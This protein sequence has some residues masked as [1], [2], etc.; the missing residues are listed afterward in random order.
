MRANLH[1]HSRF[2]DGTNWPSEVAAR[3]AAAGIEHAALTDHDTLRGGIE[4]AEA[5]AR[6]GLV[7]TLGV[8]IDCREPSL[9]Y[10]SELLAY[11]PEGAY[12]R[13]EAFLEEIQAERRRVVRSALEAA[14]RHFFNPGL[15]SFE[16]LLDRKRADRRD[17]PAER[18][19]FNKVDVYLLL[20][21][22]GLIPPDVA[23]RTFKRTYFDSRVLLDRAREKPLCAEVCRTVLSDGGVLVIPH[24]G[25]EFGDDL[26][27]LSSGI[28]RL[29]KLLKYFR[30]IGVG[31]VEL[32]YY[33]NG[34]SAEINKVVRREAKS[35]GFFTTY[36][37]DCHGV[38][39]GKDTIA[40]FNGSFDGFPLRRRNPSKERERP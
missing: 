29:R 26:G 34:A 9:G 15:S 22:A 23:Y 39:S 11:F 27:Q 31:G 10:R 8:E 36:G 7:T 17:L 24:L 37:S 20:R 40:A 6:L 3:A 35:L 32:Y 14:G 21:D 12:S 1:L 16:S 18:F 28:D 30:S 4:F 5:C 19:S 13:T 33:R 2:S 25:H 38:G